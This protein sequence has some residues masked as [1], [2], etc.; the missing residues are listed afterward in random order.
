MLIS[1]KDRQSGELRTAL[2]NNAVI[3]EMTKKTLLSRQRRSGGWDGYIHPSSLD[4][5]KSVDAQVKKLKKSW[6]PSV[7]ALRRMEVG[8]ILHE[9]IQAEIHDN[10]CKGNSVREEHMES[11]KL[12]F[13]GTYDQMAPHT[14]LGL[15][16]LEYKSIASYQRDKA[17]AESMMKKMVVPEEIREEVFNRLCVKYVEYTEPKSDHLTQVFTYIFMRKLLKLSVPER[18]SV[19]YIR[20]ETLDTMEFWYEVAKRKDL[21]KKAVDNYK[22]VFEAVLKDP[23][24]IEIRARNKEKY[25]TN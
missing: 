16:I 20:K 23:E 5:N 25:G 4:W 3:S 2:K 6:E 22:A 13:R 1:L 19:I 11:H 8:N 14:D 15:I 12:L 21:I 7:D 18:A 9:Y 10:F 24:G 17:S